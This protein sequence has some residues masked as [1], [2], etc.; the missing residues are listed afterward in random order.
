MRLGAALLV[1]TLAAGCETFEPVS[2]PLVYDRDASPD[3][4]AHAIPPLLSGWTERLG[5]DE[6]RA[7][8]LW[9]LVHYV[10]EGR[11]W[12]VGFLGADL[13]RHRVDHRGFVDFDWNVPPVFYG[14][15][16]DE[17]SYFALFPFGGTTKGLFG[18]TFAAFALFPLYVYAEDARAQG[19]PAAGAFTSH[20]VLFPF[21]NWV[22]GGG[23]S[24][25]KLFPFYAHF[26]R[27]DPDGRPAYERTWILW[28]FWT[29][30]RNNLNS[31]A[32]EQRLFFLFPFYGRSDGPKTTQWTVLWPFVRY[33]ENRGTAF[34]GPFHELRIWPFFTSSEGRERERLDIWPFWGHKWRR[35]PLATREGAYSSYERTFLLWPLVRWEREESDVAETFR[36]WVLP[37]LWSFRTRDRE[38]GGEK[39]EFK[40]WPLFRYKEWP[41]GRVRVNI[42]SPLWFEDPEGAFEM[43]YN[44]LFR[45][46]D[47]ARAENGDTR[48]LYAWGIVETRENEAQERYSWEL[49]LGLFGYAK[50]GRGRALRFFWL[51]EIAWEA[52]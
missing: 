21:V 43:I 47:K 41:D 49:L 20:H 8:F 51:P 22:H 37:L 35:V 15:S 3:L 26:E 19:P 30:Q 27:V 18:K 38:A 2:V 46:Y 45:I 32:G 14:H 52:D 4:V 39:R 48:R 50:R 12:N 24:G 29:Y 9:P 5:A 34:G 28:P 31:P 6:T 23:R 36:W 1:V 42:F 16:V 7:Y 13:I 17:G 10:R 40:V 11:S 44:P 33:F 25:F